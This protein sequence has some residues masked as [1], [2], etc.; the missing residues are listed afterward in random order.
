M[1]KRNLYQC[2]HAKVFKDRIKCEHGHFL[3]GA[4]DGSLSIFPL[5]RGNPL[6]CLSCQECFDYEEI[7]PPVKEEDRGWKEK[8]GS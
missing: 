4:K 7:G 5:I 1:E 8:K 6:E 3:G 2:A